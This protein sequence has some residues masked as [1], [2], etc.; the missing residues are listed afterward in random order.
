[1]K[2]LFTILLLSGI[3]T[4]SPV[5][6]DVEIDIGLGSGIPGCDDTNECYIPYHALVSA[7]DEITWSND[8]SVAHTVT[9]GTPAAG[10]DGKFDSSLFVTGSTYSVTLYESGE[11]PY[12]CIVHPWMTAK[13]IVDSVD[14]ESS[15]IDVSGLDEREVMEPKVGECGAGTDLVDGIC[16]VVDNSE[17]GDYLITTDDPKDEE[18]QELKNN[19]HGLKAEITEKDEEI[20]SLK[21]LIVTL[22]DEINTLKDKAV[23]DLAIILE[24]LKILNELWQTKK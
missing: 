20:N 3:F 13:V 7:G 14:F 11:Y 5:F 18:I 8:D 24:Q 9:S 17:V 16:V 12:Y 15:E 22:E 1:M 19:I 10:P 4:V 21:A 6:A 2:Y 23:D